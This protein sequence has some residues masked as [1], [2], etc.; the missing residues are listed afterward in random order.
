MNN[1]TIL[2]IL[3]FVFA[4]LNDYLGVRWHEARENGWI[5]NI[6]IITTLL[7]SVQWFP[8]LYA[9]KTQG[10]IAI[11]IADVLGSVC[12]TVTAT[13][14]YTARK[15]KETADKGCLKCCGCR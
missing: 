5:L 7:G 11:A 3:F 14:R 8:I 1:W 13:I 15:Q 6:A 9:V 10:D 2:L 12:G 4:A